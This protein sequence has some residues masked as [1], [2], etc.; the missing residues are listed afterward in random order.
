MEKIYALLNDSKDSYFQI[1][2]RSKNLRLLEIL[3]S[4]S[5]LLRSKNLLLLKV[6]ERN[7]VGE[8]N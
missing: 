4:S 3:D 5:N 2:S 7:L 6:L 1:D 8:T